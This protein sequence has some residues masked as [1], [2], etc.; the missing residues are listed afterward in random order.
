VTVVGIGMRR[1]WL[2]MGHGL[3]LLQLAQQQL[4]GLGRHSSCWP[5]LLGMRRAAQHNVSA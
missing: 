1:V 5:C 4:Q 2:L 3:G